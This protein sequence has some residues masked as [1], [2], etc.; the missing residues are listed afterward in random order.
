[1]EEILKKVGF[2][3]IEI[4]PVNIYTKEIIKGIAEQDN[5]GD[6]YSKIDLDSIDG[7]FAGAYVKAYK[8]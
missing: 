4:T 3:D 2:K 7:A 8:L 1:Y 5:L 6:V